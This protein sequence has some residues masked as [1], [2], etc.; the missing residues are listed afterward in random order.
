MLGEY[1][2]DE[3]SAT[4]TDRWALEEGY[5]SVTPTRIDITDYDVLDKLKAWEQ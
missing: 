2:N 1:R 3:P 5:V 4:D